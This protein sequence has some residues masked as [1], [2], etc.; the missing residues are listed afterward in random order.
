MTN[1]QDL[2]RLDP[3]QDV[4]E[5]GIGDHVPT[6]SPAESG[7]EEVG[8]TTSIPTMDDDVGKMVKEVTGEEPQSGETMADIINRHEK[9]RISGKDEEPEVGAG[10]PATEKNPEADALEEEGFTLPAGEESL[11]DWAQ[12]NETEEEEDLNDY[13]Q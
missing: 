7:E 12:E 3:G 1:D 11:E 6:Q 5:E 2:T 13:E 9:E 4:A 10:E 8:G